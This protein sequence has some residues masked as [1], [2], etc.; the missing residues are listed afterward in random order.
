MNN[1]FLKKAIFLLSCSGS[2]TRFE[3]Y[4]LEKFECLRCCRR[5]LLTG[6]GRR[7]AE[8][9][10]AAAAAA[11]EDGGALKAFFYVKAFFH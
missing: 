6:M 8:R 9:G 3:S 10:A 5:T 4:D 2:S 11:G 7:G 1:F